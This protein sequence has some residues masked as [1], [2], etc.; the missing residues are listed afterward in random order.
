MFT[1]ILQF[2]PASATNAT[3]VRTA[4]MTTVDCPANY[5][6]YRITGTKTEGDDGDSRGCNTK[7]TCEIFK[8][9]CKDGTDEQKKQFDIKECEASCCVSDGDTPCNSGFTVPIDM[10]MIMLAVLCSLKLM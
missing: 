7:Q 2:I 9:V 5:T 3:T 10:I 4:E 8:T 1:L 6:C